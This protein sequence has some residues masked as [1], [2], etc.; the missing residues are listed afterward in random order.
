MT[1][2]LHRKPLNLSGFLQQPGKG[3]KVLISQAIGLFCPELTLLYPVVLFE[4]FTKGL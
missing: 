1:I 4:S 3:N 2:K